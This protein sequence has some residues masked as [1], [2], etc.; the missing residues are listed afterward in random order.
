MVGQGK[1]YVYLS[2]AD[3]IPQAGN[4]CTKT[5]LHLGKKPMHLYAVE[6]L[7]FLDPR[8]IGLSG[9]LLNM[10]LCIF[11]TC[12]CLPC[13]QWD[14]YWSIFI[15]FQLRN[16]WEAKPSQEMRK[17]DAKGKGLKETQA[18]PLPDCATIH[19]FD[20]DM[21]HGT[22]LIIMCGKNTVQ[23]QGSIWVK[24][25]QSKPS[26]TQMTIYVLK[27]TFLSVK[28]NIVHAL[29]FLFFFEFLRVA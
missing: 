25:W 28:C 8:A 27:K 17:R 18:F 19:T 6:Q 21:L 10:I 26:R 2:L 15:R 7:D 1:G 11:R 3:K 23:V 16:S 14:L 9:A 29:Y 24:K 20:L 13:V 5:H 4:S 22:Y 12:A